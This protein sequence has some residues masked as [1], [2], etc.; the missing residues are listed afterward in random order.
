MSGDTNIWFASE[1]E[2]AMQ[3]LFVWLWCAPTLFCGVYQPASWVAPPP[4]L[5]HI[6]WS[7]SG[8]LV[9]SW[10]FCVLCSLASTTFAAMWCW[11]RG[12]MGFCM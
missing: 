1:V 5:D 12:S 10:T 11:G 9:W 2:M 4:Q 8:V 7:S 3:C 6:M